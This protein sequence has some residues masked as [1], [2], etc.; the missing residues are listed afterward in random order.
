MFCLS[1]KF[2]VLHGYRSLAHRHIVC[3]CFECP[4][5]CISHNKCWNGVT[6]RHSVLVSW[7]VIARK[8]LRDATRDHKQC[9]LLLLAGQRK[10][11]NLM[12]FILKC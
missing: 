2:K 1:S 5:Y 3:Y 9:R 11:N 4:F 7:H 12:F 10:L 8:G 6:I